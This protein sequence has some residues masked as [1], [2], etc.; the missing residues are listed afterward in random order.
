MILRI[1]LYG[2]TPPLSLAN[3]VRSVVFAV[4]VAAVGPPPFPSSPWH[5]AQALWYSNFPGV[6]SL[7][8]FDV[9]QR[10]GLASVIWTITDAAKLTTRQKPANVNL[11]IPTYHP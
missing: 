11:F 4:D 9:S 10:T 5:R 7:P 3:K 2:K 6:V 1:F 8:D